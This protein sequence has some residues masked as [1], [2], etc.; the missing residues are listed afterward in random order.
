MA[1]NFDFPQWM[2]KDSSFAD[3]LLKGAQVG[4][5]VANNRH[6]NQAL[7]AQ[8]ADNERNFLLREKELEAHDAQKRAV[9]QARFDEIEDMKTLSG[10]TPDRPLPSLRSPKSIATAENI[11]SLYSKSKAGRAVAAAEK[12]YHDRIEE[13]LPK[14]ALK[15]RDM[16]NESGRMTFEIADFIEQSPKR[17]KQ[18]T[19][20]D[21]EKSLTYMIGQG[22]ITQEE[23]ATLGKEKFLGPSETMEMST[24]E[25]GRPI[26]KIIKGRSATAQVSGPTTA[27][28][29]DLQKDINNTR[30]ALPLMADLEKNLRAE[31]VGLRGVV[32]ET[33]MDRL[34]PQ[35]GAG[36][37]DPKRTDNRTKLRTLVQSMLRQISPDNRFTNEDRKR[38][39]EIMPDLGVLEN[40][41][42]A[43]Q[44]LSELSKVF[45]ERNVRDMQALKAPLE[46]PQMSNEEIA[47]AVRMN[48]IDRNAALEFFRQ[49]R[50]NQ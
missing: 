10:W 2:L 7:A 36:T 28:K 8:V 18:Y 33:V 6:R 1:I 3:S 30:Q 27:V 41:D 45:S 4:A 17:E 11:Q 35:F 9:A 48:L 23:A 12:D 13:L 47:A 5:I 39:E 37:L 21:L 25:Q 31:D 40:V 50:A 26:V 42:R 49:F 43:K 44:V 46:M 34:L 24:D 20:S 32:G 16:L 15:A 14:N 29:T 38:I 22:Y 19:P